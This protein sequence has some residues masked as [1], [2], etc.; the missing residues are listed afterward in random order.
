M[1]IRDRHGVSKGLVF[2]LLEHLGSLPKP[3]EVSEWES[4]NKIDRKKLISLGIKITPIVVYFP[5]LQKEPSLSFR[6]ILWSIYSSK[7]PPED[8]NK[9]CLVLAHNLSQR[10]CAC[11]G[12][13]RFGN[14]AIKLDLLDKLASIA[15]R[16]ALKK[17]SLR[18]SEV[19]NFLDVTEVE[20]GKLMK[21]LGFLA[22]KK[23]QR[24]KYRFNQQQQRK[25]E[26]K[27]EI[28][29][30]SEKNSPFSSLRHLMIAK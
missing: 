27:K 3:L 18:K 20:F 11:I 14:K 12:L 19:S 9:K 8:K 15:R 29:V 5:K 30:T 23:G 22:H 25:K 1:C 28:G 16:R 7:R 13:R 2:R 10:D 4:L 17:V 24:T 26:Q 21:I 6:Q